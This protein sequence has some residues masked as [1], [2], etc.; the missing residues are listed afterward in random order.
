MSLELQVLGCGDA[1]GTGGR[2]QTCFSLS[3]GGDR[4]LIDCGSSAMMA[5]RQFRIDPLEIRCVVLTHLHGDHF[6]GLPFLLLDARLISKR[7]SPLVIAG[8]PGTE[9]RVLATMELLY[10]GSTSAR[11]PYDL[12]FLEME[13]ETP[14]D[15][16]R[17]RVTPWTVVHQSG[18]PAYAL[19]LEIDGHCIAYSGDTEWTGTLPVVARGADLFICEASFYEREVPNHLAYRTLMSHRQELECDRI[20]LT[21]LSQEMQDREEELELE[22]LA[23]GQIIRF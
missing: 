2:F 13:P 12:Q 23:D 14:R 8:P 7:R 22:C 1:M 3:S 21:H 5:M 16:G 19:R 18:A 9:A 4:Y 15:F 6:G 20:L 11:L 17:L 10:P